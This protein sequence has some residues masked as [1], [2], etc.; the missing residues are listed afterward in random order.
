MTIK[1]TTIIFIFFLVC[2]PVF[3]LGNGSGNAVKESG[4]VMVTGIVRL[5]G[6]VPFTEF[7]ITDNDGNDWFVFDKEREKFE[8]YQQQKVTVKADAFYNDLVLAGG[9]KVGVKRTLKNII[10]VQNG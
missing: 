7:V 2:L 6:S 8:K 4:K 1:T 5:V 9:K 3:A 10:F